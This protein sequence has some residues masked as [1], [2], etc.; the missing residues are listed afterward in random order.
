MFGDSTAY[1]SVQ[2]V[3]FSGTGG[4]RRVAEAFA[5]DMEGR[6]IE[7][8]LTALEQPGAGEKEIQAKPADLLILVFAVHA[9]DAPAPVYAWAES[10]GLEGVRAA[11][12][13]VS[14][15]GDHWP[16]TGCR[17]AICAALE[18]RGAEVFY[19][20]MMVMPCNWVIPIGDAAA[21]HLVSA[22]PDK[23]KKILDAVL[24]GRTR[25]TRS[26]M[27]FARAWVTKKEKQGTRK[28]PETISVCEDCK[29]CGWCARNCPTGNIGIKD[30][31]PVFGESC[32]MC[33]RCVYGC[34]SRALQSKNF[35][36]LK[37]GFDLDGLEKRMRGVPLPPVEE[38]FK[39][40]MWKAVREYM[41][42]EDGY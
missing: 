22:V 39:G 21:M 42:D 28:F 12:I 37:G 13:S 24:A 4:A 38:C 36:V 11:V 29:G 35:M 33:F 18:R 25:R 2:I 5:K 1:K 30:G 34:P 16:N 32:V 23:V 26:K 40:R 27:G 14:G 41:L 20:K 3:C 6:G 15:G 10:A 31:R 9:F 8:R 19:E 7:A 17:N